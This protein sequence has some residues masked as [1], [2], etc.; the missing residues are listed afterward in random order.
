M[1]RVRKKLMAAGV[2]QNLIKTASGIGYAFAL[3]HKEPTPE[4]SGAP[5]G[6]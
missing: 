4:T 1:S 2:D 6:D 5:A 3:T